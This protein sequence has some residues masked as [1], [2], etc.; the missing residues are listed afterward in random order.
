MARTYL[1]RQVLA[2]DYDYLWFTDQDAAYTP[3]T[4][5]R[6][7]A[8]DVDVVGALCP[9]REREACRPMLFR[10]VVE[11]D[12]FDEAARHLIPVDE[13][14]NYLLEYA[15]VTVNAPQAIDP[16]P[17]GS[18]LEVDFTGCHCLL[19]KRHVLEAIEP[20]WFHG[21]PGRE[22]RYFC[23][24]IRKAGF[25]VHVDF[26]TIVGHTMGDRVI[27]AYDMMAHYLYE[28]ALRGIDGTE[29]ED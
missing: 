26:S 2:G 4:L 29:T 19:I 24:K 21:M 18:L 8:W 10:G 23:L 20:P 16:I 7:M 22:D 27:G 11:G 25:K 28:S 15:D 14:Y 5:D 6:L 13:V 17:E 9:M 1:V 3:D 12:P